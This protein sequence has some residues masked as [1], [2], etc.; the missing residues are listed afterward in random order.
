MNV[1]ETIYLSAGPSSNKLCNKRL[2]GILIR[3]VQL[4]HSST[5]YQLSQYY[6]NVDERI[7]LSAG[8]SSNKLCKKG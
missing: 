4:Q 8:P 1:D 7:C 2:N 6:M 3:K 5:A